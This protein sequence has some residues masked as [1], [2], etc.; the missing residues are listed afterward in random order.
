MPLCE[1]TAVEDN[2]NNIK[3]IREIDLVDLAIE[4]NGKH[5]F[6]FGVADLV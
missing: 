2:D 4:R 6:S 5:F 3:W 1:P